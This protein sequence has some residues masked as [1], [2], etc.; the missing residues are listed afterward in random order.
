MMLAKV[1]KYQGNEKAWIGNVA[2]LLLTLIAEYQANHSMTWKDLL[3][4]LVSGILTH[5]AVWQTTNS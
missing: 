5:L 1:F 2:A 3:V 4:S